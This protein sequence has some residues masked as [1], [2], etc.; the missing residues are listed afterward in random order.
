M[1]YDKARELAKDIAESQEYTEYKRLREAA[2]ANETTA[3]L[4]KQYHQL[5][6]KAQAAQLSGQK[7]EELLGQLQKLGEVLML[8]QDA[9]GFLMAEF[10]LNQMLGD[11]YKIL[12]EAVDV[13]LGVLDEA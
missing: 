3:G 5:Q 2:M 11:V 4:I 7:D 12:A 1:V 13:D 9:S 8:N 10:R 6:L